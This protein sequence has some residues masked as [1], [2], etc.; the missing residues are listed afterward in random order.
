MSQLCVYDSPRSEHDFASLGWVHLITEIL[1]SHTPSSKQ[2]ENNRVVYN[3]ESHCCDLLKDWCTFFKCE[4]ED[5]LDRLAKRNSI[6]FD[7]TCSLPLNMY[8]FILPLVDITVMM[9]SKL[10][11]Q[12]NQ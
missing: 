8:L 2:P 6:H 3:D 5:L 12:T 10:K 9:F 1:S 11:L 4:V 7:P